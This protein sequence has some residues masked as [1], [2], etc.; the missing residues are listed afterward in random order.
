MSTARIYSWYGVLRQKGGAQLNVPFRFCASSDSP[1]LFDTR[2]KQ[3]P[4]LP[5]GLSRNFRCFKRYVYG[6]RPQPHANNSLLR[7][8]DDLKDSCLIS[9]ATDKAVFANNDYNLHTGSIN[10]DQRA[11]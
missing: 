10:L 9:V 5:Y 7:A 2:A 6:A 4:V 3:H 11:K 8:K 1:D